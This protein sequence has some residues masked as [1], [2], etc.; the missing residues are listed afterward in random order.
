[1]ARVIRLLRRHEWRIRARFAQ[2]PSPPGQHLVVLQRSD[3]IVLAIWKLHCSGVGWQALAV[4]VGVLAVP[5]SVRE[6]LERVVRSP[7]RHADVQHEVYGGDMRR[8]KGWDEAVDFGVCHADGFWVQDELDAGGV[9]R[10]CWEKIWEEF[11]NFEGWVDGEFVV[12]WL[13][14]L[15]STSRIAWNYGLFLELGCRTPKP[16][17]R[18]VTT[19]SSGAPVLPMVADV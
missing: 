16:V 15:F 9:A 14:M 13:V 3:E 12:E 17:T 19:S 4:D 10:D 8:E 1:M 6:A 5:V 7:G 18:M 11:H 2:V